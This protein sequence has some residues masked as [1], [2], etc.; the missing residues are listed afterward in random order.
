MKFLISLNKPNPIKKKISFFPTKKKNINENKKN[1]TITSGKNFSKFAANL[2][3][4]ALILTFSIAEIINGNKMINNANL[5][6]VNAAEI[7]LTNLRIV[8]EDLCYEGFLF[9]KNTTRRTMVEEEIREIEDEEF[10]YR[11]WKNA[12]VGIAIGGSGIG[13]WF[14]Y[15]G[16]HVWEKWMNEQ[17]QKDIEEE[18]EMTGTYIDPGAG[19]V[20]AS[21]DPLTGKKIVI[22]E[23]KDQ[24]KEDG[25]NKTEKNNDKDNE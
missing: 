14:A 23:K 8:K 7:N 2:K 11:N 17:E 15:K 5:S 13:M 6:K 20:D 19:N 12:Q 10:R 24:K 18:I 25:E 1:K 4:S 16:L 3:K 9:S 22:S 21:I